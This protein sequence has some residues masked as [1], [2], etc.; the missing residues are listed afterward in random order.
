MN[1]ISTLDV[2]LIEPFPVQEARRVFG[3]FH[4]YKNIVET[5]ISP[6]T[7]EEF[8]AFFKALIPNCRSYGI[9]DKNHKLSIK[10]EAPLVGIVVFEPQTVYNFYIHVAS[11]RKAWGSG[12]ID[13]ALNA[14]ID[15]VFDLVPSL[16]RISAYVL[17]NNGPVKGLAR[18]MGFKFEGVH[19]DMV[20][21]D[22][23]P[24]D[25]IHFGMTRREWEKRKT[26]SEENSNK[27]DEAPSAG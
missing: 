2:D 18:R 25:L 22:G 3:W 4:A 27:P 15:D 16:L 7:P 12:F 5:D 8:E 20:L 21:K 23:V 6:K 19:S 11:T 13:Q 17:A 14:S 9:I 1:I 26:A 10:H 24:R